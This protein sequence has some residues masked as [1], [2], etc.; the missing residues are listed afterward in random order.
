MKTH[1]RSKTRPAGFT[2]LELIIV[3]AT[4]ARMNSIYSNLRQIKDA[5][6][7]WALDQKKT[8]GTVIAEMTVLH[9]YLKR[10]AFGT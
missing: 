4:G 9:G 2:F 3:I 5:K 8:N 10:G 6:D 7:Q 1:L